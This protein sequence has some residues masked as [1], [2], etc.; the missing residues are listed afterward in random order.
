MQQHFS[1]SGSVTSS[2]VQ[3]ASTDPFPKLQPSLWY[4]HQPHHAC[5]YLCRLLINITFI[6]AEK[7]WMKKEVVALS[8]L[9]ANA[10]TRLLSLMFKVAES[11]PPIKSHWK[12]VIIV[13]LA[14][15]SWLIK[16][17]LPKGITINQKLA[18]T[19]LNAPKIFQYK[20]RV[21]FYFTL[22]SLMHRMVYVKNM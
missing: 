22:C 14:T 12:R 1:L 4:H 6:G 18:P 3:S 7:W 8:F 16:C 17:Q 13:V 2:S 20:Y 9:G 19:S 5:R 21:E 11:F 15:S 10:K